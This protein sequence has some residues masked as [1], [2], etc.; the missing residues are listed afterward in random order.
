MN[1]A[2]QKHLLRRLVHV[3]GPEHLAQITTEMSKKMWTM[4]KAHSIEEDSPTWKPF[5]GTAAMWEALQTHFNLPHS[6]KQSRGPNSWMDEFNNATNTC[7]KCQCRKTAI[8]KGKLCQTPR[9]LECEKTWS[10]CNVTPDHQ[11]DS[12]RKC[13]QDAPASVSSHTMAPSSTKKR[14]KHGSLRQHTR[15]GRAIFARNSSRPSSPQMQKERTSEGDPNPDKDQEA[16]TDDTSEEST[17]EGPSEGP[18]SPQHP[19]QNLSNPLPRSTAEGDHLEFRMQVRGWQ[20]RAHVARA[21]HLLTFPDSALLK[22]MEHITFPI[23][24][25]QHLF[26]QDHLPHQE[27]GWWYVPTAE[28]EYRTY[29][30]CKKRTPQ[31]H[32]YTSGENSQAVCTSCP[33]ATRPQHARYSESSKKKTHIRQIGQNQRD[34]LDRTAYNLQDRVQARWK[35]GLDLWDGMITA[36][37]DTRTKTYTITYDDGDS[38]T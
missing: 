19:S 33:R 36:I 24:I 29:P 21:T 28:I 18:I 11:P 31:A 6:S 9:C 14:K 35:G 16:T 12:K 34:A 37:S 17:G 13:P 4:K 30:T 32:F 10:V 38:V 27:Y 7:W 2:D 3:K 25:P 5:Q 26:P 23:L 8:C 1:E 22:T 15:V 20:D